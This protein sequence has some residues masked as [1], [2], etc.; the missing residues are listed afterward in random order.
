MPVLAAL[1]ETRSTGDTVSLLVG[2]EGGWTDRE[3]TLAAEN[4][5][6]AVSLGPSILK[7]ETAVVS[8]LAVLNAAWQVKA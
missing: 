2:P 7:T 1:P 8:A 3:R 4:D 6:R 5:W